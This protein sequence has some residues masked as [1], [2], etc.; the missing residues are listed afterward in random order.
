MPLVRTAPVPLYLLARQVREAGITVIATG[1][2][3]DELFWG[4]DLFKEV[5]LRELN[6][7]EPE[8]A[9]ELLDQLYSY[10]GPAAARRGPAWRRFLLETGADDEL[11]GSHLTRVAATAGVKALYRPEVAERDRRRCLARAAARTA[12]RRLR[13]AGAGSSA[14]PGSR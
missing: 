3:A 11:L 9:E 13:R 8:R 2:G 1:E 5:A 12:P 10:L 7:T 4:Y 14:P 6:A